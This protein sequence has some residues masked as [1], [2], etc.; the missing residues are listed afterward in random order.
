MKISFVIP[1]YRSQDTV[2][3]VI[4][5]I[6]DVVGQKKE[7]CDYEIVAVNDC[8]PDGVL[9]VLR[10]AA[11]QDPNI[12]VVDFAKN[13][14]QH[15][16]MMAGLSYTTGEYVVF[17]DDDFQC[18]VDHLW[19][20]L[21]PLEEG[22]DASCAQYKFSERKESP[23]RVLGSWFNDRM[24]RMMLD[25]PKDLRVTNF[26]AFKRFVAEEILKYQNPYPYVDGLLLRTTHNI[27]IVPM[28]D[29]ERMSGSSTYTLGKLF[30]LILNGFTAFS[31]KPLRI[32]TW[33]G[34]FAS[35]AGFLYG[36]F[37]IA[38]KIMLGDA[39]DAG[40]SSIM[41]VVLFLGGILL[42]T[43]GIIGEYIGRIYICLN[44]S[45]QYVVRG[46]FNVE[47]DHGEFRSE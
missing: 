34:I 1:C 2:M 6:R 26:I 36:I 9:A 22:Y 15:A 30:R 32:A 17:V 47:R 19:E 29:R 40:Y 43:L 38:Q 16:A 4:D 11:S 18:P 7:T 12:K 8:S 27:A 41:A 45:P 10:Q 42:L 23:F 14:G 24:L 31:V 28:E 5:E 46:T 3:A 44:N 25:K 21:K 13:F 37:I 35:V 33:A 20:L 39:I